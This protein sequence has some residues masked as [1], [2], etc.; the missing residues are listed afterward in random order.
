MAELRRRKQLRCCA[1]RPRILFEIRDFKLTGTKYY[2]GNEFLKAGMK[3]KLKK[4]PDNKFDKEAIVVKTEGLGE[5]GHVAN[6]AHTVIGESMSAGRIYDM[7][8]DTAKAKVVLVTPHGTIC[9][10][11]KKSLIDNKHKKME[12]AVDE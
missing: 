1:A 12:E 4:E 11:S 3:L 8:G 7:I 6:S 10:L 9:S 5:I 2:H